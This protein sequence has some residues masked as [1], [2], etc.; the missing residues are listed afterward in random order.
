LLGLADRINRQSNAFKTSGLSAIITS[1]NAE[2]GLKAWTDAVTAEPPA[3][4]DD[5]AAA[6]PPDASS[7]R[8]QST[9]EIVHLLL[10]QD[11]SEASAEPPSPSRSADC[12]P[13][14]RP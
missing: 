10:G 14:T 5:A 2:I 3:P 1:D 4:A 6:N 11:P 13:E 9:D 7:L 12:K 8:H